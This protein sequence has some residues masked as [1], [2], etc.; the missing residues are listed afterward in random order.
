MTAI[1]P[2]TRL[3]RTDE[4]PA[5]RGRQD[6]RHDPVPRLLVVR[7]WFDPALASRGFEPR[8]EYVERFW[9]G[10]VGPSVVLLLRRLARGLEEHPRGFA[11]D[12]DETARAIGLGTG[13]GRN[14]PLQ[15]SLD[16]AC[17]FS[18]MRRSTDGG[19]EVRTHLPRLS[20]RQLSRL[21]GSVQAT[22]AAWLARH[23]T[24]LQDRPPAA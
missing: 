1:E 7:P 18:T 6:S 21:P 24:G 9:L 12:A 10:V 19:F 20:A 8:S 22:H 16:R 4:H 3:R 11:V 23:D 15:R 14:A 17:R 13:T 2:T 5:A